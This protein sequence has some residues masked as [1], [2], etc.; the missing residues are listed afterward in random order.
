MTLLRVPYNVVVGI[1]D[2]PMHAVGGLSPL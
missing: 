2:P 1:D